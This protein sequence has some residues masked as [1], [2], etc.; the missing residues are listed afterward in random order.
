MDHVYFPVKTGGC[1]QTQNWQEKCH[2]IDTLLITLRAWK[3]LAL[4]C[5]VQEGILYVSGLCKIS[6]NLC[7]LKILFSN[8]TSEK[9]RQQSNSPPTVTVT[10]ANTYFVVELKHQDTSLSRNTS[11]L[12]FLL[13]AHILF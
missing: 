1:D 8:K 9:N 10:N 2:V 6:R 7:F 11:L 5:S 12:F 3:M 4:P 13:K